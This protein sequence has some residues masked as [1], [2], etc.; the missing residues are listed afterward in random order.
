MTNFKL[1]LLCIYLFLLTSGCTDNKNPAEIKNNIATVSESI[2]MDLTLLKKDVTYTVISDVMLEF[3]D[4]FLGKRIM[5][6]GDFY[7]THDEVTNQ[8]CHYLLVE[9]E[10][11]CCG[12][13]L[14][15]IW[16]GEHIYPDDYPKDYET[17]EV[18][19]VFSSYEKSGYTFYY[20]AIDGNPD[21]S[22]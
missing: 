18:I 15:L 14:E 8:Y 2:D 19:G 5:V 6:S 12:E 17:I 10:D 9:D 7:S 3:P 16:K 20:L 21:P 13:E 4:V 22:S 11:A 1:I